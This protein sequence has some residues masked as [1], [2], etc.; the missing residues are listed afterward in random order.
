MQHNIPVQTLTSHMLTSLC[1]YEWALPI[2]TENVSKLSPQAWDI[3]R[4]K[5]W[6]QHMLHRRVSNP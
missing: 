3:L 5:S 4:D 1:H 6:A 2:I